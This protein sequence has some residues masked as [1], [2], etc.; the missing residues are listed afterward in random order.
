MAYYPL[1][2]AHTNRFTRAVYLKDSILMVKFLVLLPLAVV[3]V[4]LL[5]VH[6]AGGGEEE[7]KVDAYFQL[8]HK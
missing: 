1:S 3:V 8:P 6:I 2:F 5:L 7:I 4:A